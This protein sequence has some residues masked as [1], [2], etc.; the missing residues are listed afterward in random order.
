MELETT[1][2]GIVFFVNFILT[3]IQWGGTESYHGVGI[4]ISKFDPLQ[5]MIS[6]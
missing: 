1:I 3:V 6:L 4:Q 2:F 5:Q